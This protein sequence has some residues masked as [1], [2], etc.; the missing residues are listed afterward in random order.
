MLEP[1][2]LT[3]Y[4][5]PSTIERVD[6]L[7]WYYNYDI[8]SEKLELPEDLDLIAPIPGDYIYNFIQIEFNSEPDY[9]SCVEAVIRQYITQSQEFDLINSFNKSALFGVETSDK[10]IN[11]YKEYLDKIKEIKEKV[12]KDFNK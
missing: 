5:K 9:K 3:S 12:K 8:K 4:I 1:I 2:R 7:K 6:K 10:D 11:K